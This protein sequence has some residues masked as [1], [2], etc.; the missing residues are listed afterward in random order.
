MLDTFIVIND[1]VQDLSDDDRIS[2]FLTA[3]SMCSWEL[4]VGSDDSEGE[5]PPPPVLIEDGGLTTEE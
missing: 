1:D 5:T 4:S 3:P 2:I